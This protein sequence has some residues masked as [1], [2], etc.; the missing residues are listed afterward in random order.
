ML[1]NSKSFQNI[2]IVEAKNVRVV[3]TP[4]NEQIGCNKSKCV[5]S[6]KKIGKSTS[7]EKKN[8]NL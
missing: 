2:P 1:H 5:E 3:F 8:C 7:I 6:S 4:L